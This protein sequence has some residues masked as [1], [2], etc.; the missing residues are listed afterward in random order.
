MTAE[1]QVLGVM[2]LRSRDRAFTEGEERLLANIAHL[3]ALALRSARLYEERA[4]AFADLTVAQAQLVRREKLSALGEMASGVA[5]D[6]NNLLA[7]IVGRAQLLLLQVEDPKHRQWL[8]VIER[9]A[10]DGAK[11]VRRLQEFTR[12]RRDQSFVPVDLNRIIQQTLEV[13]ETRWRHDP[14]ARGITLDVRTALDPALPAVSGDAAELREAL[15]NMVLNAL[16]AMPR[17][18]TLA[19]TT[20]AAGEHVQVTVEDTGI[21]MPLHVKQR[22]FDPFFTTKGSR[23]TGLGLSMTYGILSRHGARVDVESEEGKGTT[24][25]LRF[26]V[27]QGRAAE[28][29]APPAA[30][31]SAGPIRCLVVDDEEEVGDT[32]GDILTSH[33]HHVTVLRAGDE[34]LV[35]FRQEAFDAVFTDLSMPGLSGWDVAKEVREVAPDVPVFLCTGF[36]VEVPPEQLATS[37]VSAVL[38]KPLRIEDVRAAVASV[39]L[40]PRP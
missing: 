29:S 26:P 11:T 37:G 2:A 33:G 4:R 23:G 24:F 35:R 27:A 6:F 20:S 15:T 13:T 40:R 36:G 1:E 10:L 12:I 19:L 14:Q 5:H 9:S 38:P 17:G 39:R 7:S 16:D 32:L 21:G 30:P 25:I 3:A 8:Q 31:A 22:I 28:E 34:A 18:G